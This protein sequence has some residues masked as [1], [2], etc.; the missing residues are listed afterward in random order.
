MRRRSSMKKNLMSILI[1]ALLVVNIAL[2]AIM[3]F[4]VMGAMKSTTS[5]VGKI[6]AVL[7][8]ELNLDT[9]GEEVA[10]ADSV[11]FDIATMTI[12]LKGE[13]TENEDQHYAM[14]AVSIQMDKKNKDYKTYSESLTA[15]ESMIK[16]EII[17]VISSH[18]VEEFRNDTDGIRQEILSRLQRMYNSDFIYKVVF[19]DWK[20][21]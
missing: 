8:L 4:S 13:G 21:Q 2:T 18:T 11:P 20:I 10:I 5:L 16:G 19:S 12:P 9:E 15:N 7:D 6:A 14:V 1:L 17:E 3:M